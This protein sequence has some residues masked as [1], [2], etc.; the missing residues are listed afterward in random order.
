MCASESWDDRLADDREERTRPCELELDAP[1]VLRHPECMRRPRRVGR[2]TGELVLRRRVGEE[3]LEHAERRLPELRR[4]D[5]APFTRKRVVVLDRQRPP[6]CERLAGQLVGPIERA[7]GGVAA[8]RDDLD[9]PIL[10]RPPQRCARGARGLEREANRVLRSAAR[11]ATGRQRLACDLEQ[12]DRAVAPSGRGLPGGRPQRE[13]ELSRRKIRERLVLGVERVVCAQDLDRAHDVARKFGRGHDHSG[14]QAGRTAVARRRSRRRPRSDEPGG[15][16]GLGGRDGSRDERA[17]DRIDDANGADVGA[18][19]L[20]DGLREQ[21]ERRRELEAGREARGDVSEA[22]DG[23]A[24]GIDGHRAVQYDRAARRRRARSTRER[25]RDSTSMRP[26]AE[27]A[28]RAP[29]AD[30]DSPSLDPAAIE[31]AY[32]RERARRRAR[33]ERRSAAKRSNMRFWLVLA[34]LAFL[35]VVLA[36]TVWSEIQRMFGV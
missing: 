32:A 13:C 29:T 33:V 5:V 22:L 4:C 7:V 31:R 25:Q 23:Q 1:H 2:E 17:V 36:L 28:R 21:L 34:L 6:G 24:L 15:E 19:R 12:A 14:E 11:V 9:D 20:D 8:E 27:P 30:E 10:R 3:E 16:R 35:T 18:G 26:M